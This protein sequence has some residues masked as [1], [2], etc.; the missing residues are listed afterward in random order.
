ME[1]AQKTDLENGIVWLHSILSSLDINDFK[2]EKVLSQQKFDF[3]N[4][5]I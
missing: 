4:S 3:L 1:R 5:N 2:L